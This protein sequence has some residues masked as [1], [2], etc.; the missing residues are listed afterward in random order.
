MG[1]KPS[2]SGAR[3]LATLEKIAVLQPVG[4]SDLARGL[5]ENLSAVQR[6]VQTLADEGWIRA[7]PGR[8]VR[9]ELT[10]HI[11]SVAQRALGGNDLRRRAHA[12]LEALREETGESVILNVPDGGKFVVID[13][14][15]S[16]H[17]LR[18]SA[19][20]GLIVPAKASATAW[21]LLPYMTADQ[22]IEYVG[23]PPDAAMRAHFADTI[24]RGYAISMGDVVPGSTNIAAPI[25]EFDG[26]PIGAVLVSAPNDRA[27]IDDYARLGTLVAATA[28]RLSRGSPASVPSYDQAKPAR[29]PKVHAPPER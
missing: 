18:I 29:E 26:R 25:F 23:E 14:L 4:V 11:H 10:A 22:Q 13:V 24:E 12:L 3:I 5:D 20:V 15:E 19:P 2:Q 21:A 27:S 16:P 17:Y 28:R 1:V 7:A 8:P 6:A 9:W